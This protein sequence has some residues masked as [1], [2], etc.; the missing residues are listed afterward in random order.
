MPLKDEKIQDNRTRP[1]PEIGC[2]STYPAPPASMLVRRMPSSDAACPDRRNGGVTATAATR[3]EREPSMSACSPFT[4]KEGAG[5]VGI[6]PCGTP[7]NLLCLSSRAGCGLGSVELAVDL[8]GEVALQ[9]AADL[10]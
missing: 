1:T 9:A 4:V 3:V 8:T 7:L 10:S 5:W 2:R 6:D